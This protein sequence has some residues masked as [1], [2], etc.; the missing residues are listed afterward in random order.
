MI[1]VFALLFISLL[2][3]CQSDNTQTETDLNYFDIKGFFT[4]D[5]ARLRK[6]NHITHKTVKHNGITET[7]DVHITNWGLELS[8]FSQSDINK[9]AWR[10]SYIIEKGNNI[11][12]YRAKYPDLKTREIIIKKEGGKVKWILISNATK[13]VLYQTKEKLSYFP[14]S[15]YI[16]QKYQKVRLLSANQYVVK[17]SLN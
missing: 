8:L 2:P 15:I 10:N 6:L 4:A 13:N 9:P 16:I 5:T 12:I 14:D 3:S 17:G 1:I 11:E 7:K